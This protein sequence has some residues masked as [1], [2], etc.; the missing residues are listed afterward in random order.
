MLKQQVKNKKKGGF[1]LQL[2]I[3]DYHNLSQ[4]QEIKTRN[5]SLRLLSSIKDSHVKVDS[6]GIESYLKRLT[7]LQRKIVENVFF[8]FRKEGHS[9]LKNETIAREIGCSVKTVTRC[10]NK[11]HS[12]GFITKWQQ[13]KYSP[14]HYDF[15]KDIVKGRQAYD[16]WFNTLSVKNQ[17]LYTTNGIR[18]DYKNRI[19][20]S[21]R[22]VP[23][24]TILSYCKRFISKKP[25]PIVRA[26]TYTR[27]DNSDFENVFLNLKPID[28]NG[29]VFKKL[30]REERFKKAVELM[31]DIQ[32][33]FILE[34]KTDPRV[35]NMLNYPK[36]RTV[37]ITP[38]IEKLTQMLALN[39][40]EQLKM[41]AFRDE[42]LQYAL[43]YIEPIIMG[44]K[45]LKAP[46]RDRMGWLMGILN[47]FCEKNRITPDWSWYFEICSIVGIEALQK[48]EESKPLVLE[49]SPQQVYK[50]VETV[51]QISPQQEIDKLKEDIEGFE[52]QLAAPESFWDPKS[53]LY[54]TMIAT[55]KKFHER[56]LI[57]LKEIEKNMST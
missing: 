35:K 15:K 57:H 37:L 53:F 22:N 7:P 21:H 25:K 41:V 45:Q 17:T 34:H 42:A 36:I 29:S 28:G 55:T 30:T 39:Q 47:Q 48:G 5:L 13:N 52:L 16:Y 19:I 10:T 32:K 43:N 31:N 1:I 33:K 40:R 6:C 20:F 38:L 8:K 50:R 4:N 56:A 54:E 18:V 27:E 49:K 44:K 11:L 46:V 51:K 12:D 3:R 9:Y 23:Q 14:N 2:R 26:H 24:N